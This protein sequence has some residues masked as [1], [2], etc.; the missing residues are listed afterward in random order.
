MTARL[1]A[2]AAT[3][4]AVVLVALMVSDMH[5]TRADA[6][7]GL[8]PDARAAL[9]KLYQIQPRAKELG[10][11]AKGI[12]VFP[13]VG[14]AGFL[15]GVHYGE[16]VLFQGDQI[17]GYYNVAGASYG[18]QVGAQV[19]AYAMFFMTD[20]ALEYLSKS[21]GFEV[22]VGPNVVIVD[23]GKAKTLTTTTARDDVYAFVFGQKGLMAGLGLQGSKISKVG[24]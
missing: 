19:F 23:A 12:L 20:S 14:K 5:R 22:G 13:S 3:G 1:R 9:A 16:G 4:L 24:R 6:V 18:L 10:A 15:V 2:V 17:I 8:D 21:E 11:Q 7:E